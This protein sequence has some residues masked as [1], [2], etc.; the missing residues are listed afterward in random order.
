MAISEAYASTEAITVAD[1]WSLTGDDTSPDTTG[2]T[3]DG[4]YQCFLDLSDMVTSDYLTFKIYEKVQAAD[5][6]RVVFT[7]SF[8]H[9]QGDP[10]WVSPAM[11]LMH[12]WEMTVKVDAGSTCTVNWSIRKVA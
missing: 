8:A 12:G 10:N 11:V 9:V 7:A 2:I 5:T 4:V 1:E 6:Q 3:T